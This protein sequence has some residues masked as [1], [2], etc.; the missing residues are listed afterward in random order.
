MSVVG[1]EALTLQTIIVNWLLWPVIVPILVSRQRQT[2]CLFKFLVSLPSNFRIRIEFGRSITFV[3][4]IE[5]GHA[6][7]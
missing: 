4:D 7:R 2:L 6:H 5:K 1:P 3:F